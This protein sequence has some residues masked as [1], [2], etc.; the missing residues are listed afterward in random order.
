MGTATG[1]SGVL[2]HMAEFD[3][4][5]EVYDTTRGL[6]EGEM[7]MVLEALAGMLNPRWRVF[8]AAVGTGRFAAP[9]SEFGFEVV[10]ADISAKMMEKAREKGF[11]GLLRATISDLPLRDGAIDATIVVH[12]LHLVAD[13]RASLREIGRVTRRAVLS[14]VESTE[15]DLIRETYL[16]LRRD[17]GFPLPQDKLDGGERGLMKIVSPRQ[18]VEI[19]KKAEEVRAVDDIST[20]ERKSGP[21]HGTCQRKSTER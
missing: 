20:Y 4:I 14:V 17:L 7:L 12:V 8:D 1:A 6:P 3:K 19:L 15:N 5:A 2:F 16:T 10:G 9:L 18:V 21:S 11:G 13:W